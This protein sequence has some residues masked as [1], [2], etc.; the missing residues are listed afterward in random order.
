MQQ[1]HKQEVLL[2]EQLHSQYTVGVFLVG[3]L[4]VC[5]VFL[6]VVFCFLL[7]LALQGKDMRNELVL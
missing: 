1:S 2:I 3:F 6:R 7:E 5:W 4:F